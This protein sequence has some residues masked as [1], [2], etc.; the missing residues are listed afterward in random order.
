[1][2]PFFKR[3]CRHRLTPILLV[4]I[5][6]LPMDAAEIARGS[7]DEPTALPDW[8]V[9]MYMAGDNNLEDAAIDDFNELETVGSTDRV[10]IIAQIDRSKRNDETNGDW[11]D[12]RRYRIT[13]DSDRDIMHS[14]LLNGSLGELDMS[15]PDTLVDFLLWG[16]N[17]Y[18]AR[19]YLVVL[20]D[21]GQGWYG[22]VLLD[23]GYYMPI[24]DLRD[25]LTEV[26][27]QW[28]HTFDVLGFDA[29]LMG[30]IEVYY[31]LNG[32]V[33]YSFGSGKN[34]PTDGLPYN[35]F[36]LDLV[37]E[38]EMSEEELLDEIASDYVR[39]YRDRSP[40]SV[41]NAGINI[42]RLSD[43]PEAL[44][45]FSE[46]I[47]R[48]MPYY[49][50][51]VL[52]AKNVTEEYEYAESNN[53]DYFDF[54]DFIHQ[55]KKRIRNPRF[56]TVAQALQ[57]ALEGSIVSHHAWSVPGKDSDTVLN[58]TGM[59]VFFPDPN[60]GVTS[61][62]KRVAYS[63]TQF[64]M[65]TLWDEFLAELFHYNDDDYLAS[66]EVHSD[67]THEMEIADSDA[68]G[69]EDSFILN[70]HLN[71]HK[72]GSTDNLTL[73]VL[74]VN[75]QN[76]LVHQQEILSPDSEGVLDFN[77]KEVGFDN[78]SYN[79]L[80]W[81]D[82]GILQDVIMYTHDF[83]VYGV[84]LD[85]TMM[86]DQG[87]EVPVDTIWIEPTENITIN[88][89]VTNL[90]NSREAFRIEATGVPLKFEVSYDV[91]PFGMDPEEIRVFLFTISALE[92]IGSGSDTFHIS[93]RCVD[94]LSLQ[95]GDLV[96]VNVRGD[97]KDK[98]DPMTPI[99]LMM[100]ALM[101]IVVL[102]G[103]SRMRTSREMK[104]IEDQ[105]NKPIDP[106]VEELLN[107]TRN[108]VEHKEPGSN[109]VRESGKTG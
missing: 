101:L 46:E 29:C 50:P 91:D 70:Y 56:L 22:G 105:M 8:T 82:Q 100:I 11:T 31:Q 3:G 97:E 73:E 88:L 72:G 51:E 32:F 38:P 90:G 94:N 41:H 7:R 49:L 21:H 13:K 30:G 16:V 98:P 37:N 74:V 109:S 85:I 2:P 23:E 24:T 34:E 47:Q 66:R 107:F 79:V 15:D 89:K 18:P 39:S 103:V 71:D 106:E 19:R 104:D 10:N 77:V 102:L 4:V 6:L 96:T 62:P 69:Q 45:A 75:E 108:L 92:R 59:T 27:A 78:Y 33:N 44:D 36:I 93:V 55:V 67:I 17:N 83:R 68:N 80:V 76:T 64:A 5:L 58:S 52:D 40:I 99:I 61:V 25:A 1:M 81:D 60:T 57:D 9:L 43:V 12:T 53:Y 54:L 35:D 63:D 26:R 65:D 87:Y 14:E 48:Q 20:W 84:Q 86:D 28:N 95:D 42:T